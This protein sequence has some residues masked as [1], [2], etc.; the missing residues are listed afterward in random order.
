[1]YFQSFQNELNALSNTSP[2]TQE[3]IKARK[4]FYEKWFDVDFFIKTY[5]VNILCGMDD[6]YW[7]NANNYYLYFDNSKKGSGKCYFIPFDYDNTLGGSISGDRVTTNPLEWGITADGVRHDR[8][9]LDRLLEVPE[10]LNKMKTTLKVVASQDSS[11]PWNKDHCFDIWDQW[12]AQVEPYINTTDIA[13]SPNMVS[14]YFADEAGKG[15]YITRGHSTNLYEEVTQN[16]NSR[17]ASDDVTISFNLNDGTDTVK[18]GIYTGV[19]KSFSSMIDDPVHAGY[20]FIGWTKTKDGTDFINQYNG[21]SNLTV[22]GKW[23]DIQGVTGLYIYEIKDS[24]YEGIK[25]AI[26][27]LPENH[28]RRSIY[29]NDKEVSGNSQEDSGKYGKIWCYPYTEFGK[30]YTVKVSYSTKGYQWLETSNEITVEATSGKGAFK[31]TNTPVY[32]IEDNVLLWNTHPTIQIGDSGTPKTSNNW[33]EYYAMEVQSTKTTIKGKE[34]DWNYQSWN[35]LGASCDIGFNFKNHVNKEV[36]DGTYK[37][38]VFR[39][40]Y[41]YNTPT[42]TLFLTVL[43]YDTSKAFNIE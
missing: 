34:G 25:I 37:D 19:N 21:E 7:G 38:L 9:L 32:K 22:Y 12:K 20:D 4:D 17:F 3:G 28:Y 29:I 8:P 26:I 41:V 27:N 1:V 5:A 35:H 30:T 36:L 11:S 13:D 6:D 14:K 15:H 39:I 16:I 18:T 31:I 33:D 40:R 24:T 43:D 23:Q 10:Y 42:G 2:H